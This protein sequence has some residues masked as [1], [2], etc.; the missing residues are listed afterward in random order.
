MKYIKN[1]QSDHSKYFVQKLIMDP[2][3]QNLNII[4]PY[5][6]CNIFLMFVFILKKVKGTLQNIMS[7]D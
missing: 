6:T 5:L 7:V 3:I 2:N 4:D 1:T